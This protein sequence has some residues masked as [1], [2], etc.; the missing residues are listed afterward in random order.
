M[1]KNIYDV[2]ICGSG[3]AGLTLARQLKLKMPDISVVVIDRLGR[4][5]PEA[6]FKVGES[7]VEVGAYYLANVVQLE[8]YLEK[9]HLHKLGLRYFLGDTSGPFHKRPEIGLSEFHLPNSYQ[10]DRGKLENDL[11]SLN[12]EA[13]VELLEHCLVKDI[14]LATSSQNLHQILYIQGNN[15]ITQTIQA[16]WVVDSMGYRRFLQSKLGLAKPKNSQFSAVWFRIEGRF[17][18]S[19]FVPST[20]KQWHERVPNNNR[21]Y[22]TNHLCGEGYWVWLIPLSTGYTSIGIVTNEDVHPFRTYH[23]YEK[24]YQWLEKHEPVVALHLR[25]KPLVDFMKIPQYSY[26]SNQIFSVNRW[27]CVGVAGVFADPFYSPGTDLIGFGNSLITQMI[28]LD[29]EGKLTQQTVNEAN[30]FLL[31]Y[32]ESV[33]LNIHNAYL[34]FG[35]EMVM[36]M[37]YIWDVLSAWAFSAPLM[38]NS[39]FLDSDKRAKVRKGTGQ[40]FLLAQRVNQLFRD[41]LAKSKRRASFEF[42]DY[43]RIPFVKELRSRNLKTNKT[44][45]EL[46]D[47]HLASIKL[48]EEL[49]QVIFLLALEDTMPEKLADFPSPVWLNAWAISLDHERWEIDRLFQPISQPRD[50]R[51]IMQQLRENI[52]FRSV[53]CFAGSLSN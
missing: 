30:R 1:H 3:L 40:F 6:S 4:P 51:P 13:G 24:A 52:H 47:D 25:S 29:R 48:F 34:C 21:Y 16:R 19:D 35:N 43:L 44:E 41:W 10:I 32:N 27:A 39:L 5:L 26:S 33:T 28:E 20:E 36:A 31:T 17:D 18:V 46:I 8:D 12:A 14:E 7:S 38:F 37:K 50:L 9:H 53:R 2:A 23:S 11:R 42:I 15:K 49:A 45:Q 22:S